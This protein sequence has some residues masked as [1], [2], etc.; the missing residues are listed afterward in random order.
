[1]VFVFGKIFRSG[2]PRIPWASYLIFNAPI[3]IFY[4]SVLWI[5]IMH[6]CALLQHLNAL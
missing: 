1:M 6:L 4:D 3:L 5:Q 2:E